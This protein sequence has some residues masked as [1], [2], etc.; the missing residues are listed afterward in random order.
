MRAEAEAGEK[1][2]EEGADHQEGQH[3]VE[4][5]AR[6]LPDAAEVQDVQRQ[7]DHEEVV[8]PGE[9]PQLTISQHQDPA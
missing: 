2:E 9:H 6:A 7:G 8:P 3:W 1:A 4:S 5:F